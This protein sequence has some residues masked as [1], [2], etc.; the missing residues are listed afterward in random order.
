MGKGDFLQLDL[1][2]GELSVNNSSKDL[3]PLTPQNNEW[4]GSQILIRNDRNLVMPSHHE[5]R[6]Q[7][8][9]LK[10]LEQY[11]QQPTKAVT[12]TLKACF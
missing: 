8:V 12:K 7:D 1:F 6:A 11:L 2:D 5:I 4:Q 10:D 9:D 3:L